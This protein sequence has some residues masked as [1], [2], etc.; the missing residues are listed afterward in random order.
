MSWTRR[1]FLQSLASL[2][3]GLVAAAADLLGHDL[4]VAELAGRSDDREDVLLI[5]NIALRFQPTEEMMADYRKTM[6]EEMAKLP[7]SVKNRFQGMGGQGGN[8]GIICDF[9]QFCYKI[10]YYYFIRI[11]IN[12]ITEIV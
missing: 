9:F 4:A 11:F 5:P 12:T 6:E 10:L 3:V 2:P 1:G 8:R 7:D